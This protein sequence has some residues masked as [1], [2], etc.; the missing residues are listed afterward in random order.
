L[1]N[2]A[3]SENFIYGWTNRGVQQVLNTWQGNGMLTVIGGDLDCNQNEWTTQ[4]PNP[5]SYTNAYCFDNR[6]TVLVVSDCELLKTAS[7]L[8]YAMKGKD[9]KLNNCK[10]ESVANDSDFD[11]V[12]VHGN[13]QLNITNDKILPIKER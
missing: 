8:G 2:A 5:F 3:Q 10:I 9:F 4:T 12:V 11:K 6:N 1:P 13:L 7:A